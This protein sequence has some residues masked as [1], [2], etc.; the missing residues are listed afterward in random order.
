MLEIISDSFL[1]CPFA[2]RYFWHETSK[3]QKSLHG[4]QKKSRLWQ[5]PIKYYV[6]NYAYRSE[7]TEFLDSAQFNRHHKWTKHPRPIV[8]EHLIYWFD[9]RPILQQ[10]T[11]A[12]NQ[13]R[14]VNVWSSLSCDS[15]DFSSLKSFQHSI[16]VL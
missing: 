15:I 1:N 14:V 8:T 16:Y 12:Y 2:A 5:Y 13:Q 3:W 4:H 9:L 6:Y 11:V 7:M 10:I